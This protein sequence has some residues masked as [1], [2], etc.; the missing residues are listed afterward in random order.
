MTKFVKFLTLS[1]TALFLSGFFV[2]EVYAEGE[3]EIDILDAISYMS[4]SGDT[5]D[6]SLHFLDSFRFGPGCTYELRIPIRNVTVGKDIEVSTQIGQLPAELTVTERFDFPI[7]FNW[8]GAGRDIVL[9]VETSEDLTGLP[10]QT[11]LSFDVNFYASTVGGSEND[12]VGQTK[13]TYS[14][15]RAVINQPDSSVPTI[16]VHGILGNGADLITP[17]DDW[18]TLEDDNFCRLFLKYEKDLLG[19]EWCSAVDWSTLE[20][21]FDQNDVEYYR[22][23]YNWTRPNSEN[24]SDLAT[25]INAVKQETGSEKVN[26]V[27]H[28][29]GGLLIREYIDSIESEEDLGIHKVA[30]IT[31][32]LYGTDAARASWYG[33]DIEWMKGFAPKPLHWVVDGWFSSP[34]GWLTDPIFHSNTDFIVRTSLPIVNNLMS[35][36]DESMIVPETDLGWTDSVFDRV[37]SGEDNLVLRQQYSDDSQDSI[38]TS[39]RISSLFITSDV[40][41]STPTSSQLIPF[42]NLNQFSQMKNNLSFFDQW[43]INHSQ[44][45]FLYHSTVFGEGD[46]VVPTESMT[47]GC[48]WQGSTCITDAGVEWERYEVDV[49]HVHSPDAS[50]AKVAEYLY[51]DIE[52]VYGTLPIAPYKKSGIVVVESAADSSVVL[53]DGSQVSLES[54]VEEWID[55]GVAPYK[56]EGED[57]VIYFV[58]DLDKQDLTVKLDAG[59]SQSES[60]EYVIG[61]S[62]S[63]DTGSQ[64]DVVE[65]EVESGKQKGI[66]VSIPQGEFVEDIDPEESEALEVT[67]LAP[68]ARIQEEVYEVERMNFLRFDGSESYD[69]EGEELEYR[70]SVEGMFTTS[71]R[72]TPRYTR[73][74]TQEYEGMIRLEVRDG[75]SVT[76]VESELR[77][78]PIEDVS[79]ALRQKVH[80]ISPDTNYTHQKRQ[81]WLTILDYID[82]Y[83]MHEQYVES[84]YVYLERS[85]RFA[86]QEDYE[87]GEG[88]I[89]DRNEGII[90]EMYN[91]L[92]FR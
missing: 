15:S 54:G 12:F 48:D 53:S 46:G 20:Q 83:H 51:P 6:C 43:A 23:S 69:P 73:K 70:W 89:S 11:D 25:F 64:R 71:W 65:G 75:E 42:S 74:F 58:E 17:Y 4:I 34:L 52:P 86:L 50:A 77:I 33:G 2:S 14:V 35:V 67:N 45:R 56:V 80:S 91:I 8:N 81:T 41:Q 57:R 60:E 88:L 55:T 38:N 29:N 39:E 66:G 47:F 24:V 9:Y 30:Y 84:L 59:E 82:R 40:N 22:Y 85:I 68:V 21:E 61:F 13:V 72:S 76:T 10:Q 37:L 63:D 92:L 5:Y 27:G 26:L 36:Y 31:S 16:L 87:Q 79:A 28:S 3:L 78:T 90:M 18:K 49:D 1:L 44:G 32:P 19:R 7:R 62:G